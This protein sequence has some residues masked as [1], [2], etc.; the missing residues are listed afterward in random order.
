MSLWTFIICVDKVS[1]YRMIGEVK[2]S[3][4]SSYVCNL[5]SMAANLLSID[6]M[7]QISID[8]AGCWSF[9]R[10]V[11]KSCCSRSILVLNQSTLLLRVLYTSLIFVLMYAI[12]YSSFFSAKL[13]GPAGIWDVCGLTSIDVALLA[14]IDG[15]VLA[16]FSRMC[17]IL[18][19]SVLICA[20]LLKNSL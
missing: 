17:C 13:S 19:I 20:I 7:V 5:S 15:D 2:R 10:M 16:S 3:C 18:S 4:I 11:S 8:V 14:S 1:K 9:L 6:V 12:S